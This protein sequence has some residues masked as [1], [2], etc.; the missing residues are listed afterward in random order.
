MAIQ[1]I[2]FT[3]FLGILSLVIGHTIIDLY[4]NKITETVKSKL[5]AGTQTDTG[6]VQ[7]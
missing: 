7:K 4:G 2:L 6:V 3:I 1:N 5:P